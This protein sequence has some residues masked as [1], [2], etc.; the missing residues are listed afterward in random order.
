[1]A[2]EIMRSARTK[3]RDDDDFSRP[4]ALVEPAMTD[5]DHL[6][7]NA[8]SH[9][10]DGLTA[11]MLPKMLDYWSSIGTASAPAP[12]TRSTAAELG[13]YRRSRYQRPA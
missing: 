13:S 10:K 1:M 9:I 3:R 8:A 12:P 7:T 6:V 4:R 2:G 11:A 5:E